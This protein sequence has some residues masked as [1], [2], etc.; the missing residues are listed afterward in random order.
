MMTKAR[1]NIPT[2]V[3]SGKQGDKNIIRVFDIP[4]NMTKYCW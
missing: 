1:D 3:L 2:K 4:G